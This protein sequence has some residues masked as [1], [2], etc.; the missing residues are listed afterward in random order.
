MWFVVR[1]I[2]RANKSILIDRITQMKAVAS[3]I[4]TSV[5]QFQS[6]AMLYAIEQELNVS[7]VRRGNLC[8]DL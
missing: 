1:C 2:W 6:R 4:N 7:I 8:N 3:E 5:A